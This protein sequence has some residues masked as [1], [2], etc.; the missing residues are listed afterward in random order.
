MT[1]GIEYIHGWVRTLELKRY[2]KDSLPSTV[3]AIMRFLFKDILL[4]IF[5]YKGQKGK[6]VFYTLTICSVIFDSIKLKKKFNKYDT[7]D[8]ETPLRIF[9]SGAKFRDI[10]KTKIIQAADNTIYSGTSISRK[11]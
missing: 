3:R 8:V 11:P 6:K 5:S 7:I 9:I 1:T 10:P 2:A 4:N